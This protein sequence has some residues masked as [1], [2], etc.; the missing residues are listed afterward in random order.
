MNASAYTVKPIETLEALSEIGD[1]WD[2]LYTNSNTNHVMLSH[3]FIFQWWRCFGET[4][5][6]KTLLIYKEDSLVA[7]VP[8][9]ISAGRERLPI[10]DPYVLIA[11]DYQHLPH[12]HK[13]CWFNIR[14][15]S[16]PLSIP[17][18]NIRG[19]V[20]STEPL[21]RLIKPICHYLKAIA[22]EWD[23]AI[24]DG[25]KKS[26]NIKELLSTTKSGLALGKRVSESHL[27]E[28]HLTA[29]VHS[30]WQNK[31]SHFRKRAKAEIRKLSDFAQEHGGFRI[32]LFR[33]NTICEGVEI[34][35]TLETKSWKVNGEKERTLHLALDD[36]MREFHRSTA[37][38][39]ADQDQAEIT[40]LFAGER[41]LACLYSLE[42]TTCSSMILTYRD[43][44]LPSG[45]GI[46][47]C[48][49]ESKIKAGIEKRF[50][51][52]DIN[53]YTRNYI[54][55][56]THTIKY[57]RALVFNQTPYSRLLKFIDNC[58]F[59]LAKLKPVGPV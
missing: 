57:E 46:I 8:F 34:M 18:A 15:L 17:S 25:L 42:N 33:K 45:L 41:P 7:I 30:F 23:V 13:Q 9:C 47:P 1:A 12:L 24:F 19:G 43:A 53:G 3:R 56:A 35:F 50:Q 39:F 4:K 28:L 55:W 54:K 14:R 26:E 36:S 52:I 44:S 40:V 11:S 27:L 51:F 29:D 48:L 38:A 59:A 6:Q 10:R 5:T 32:E 58:A 31:S 37:Q 16:F 22:H 2:L 20:I 49:W 21:S